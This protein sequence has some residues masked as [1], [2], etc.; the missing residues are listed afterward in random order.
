VPVV[1]L[2]ELGGLA[3][4]LAA[5]VRASGF[6][7]DVLV[8]VE[9]GARLVAHEVG[10]ELGVEV[11]PMWVRRGGSGLKARVAPWVARLPVWVR[12]GLRRLE[13]RSGVHRHTSR[14]AALAEGVVLAGKRVLLLD[15]AADTGRT[16][17]VARELVKTK[18]GAAEVKVAVLAA[19]TPAGRAEV[20]FFVLEKNSRMPWSSDSDERTEAERRAEELR[21]RH[22]PRDF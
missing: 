13:E 12:D 3:G 17:A 14:A 7:A 15:D 21:P 1:T 6:R 16:I 22:A 4:E 20:D 2:G 10:R 9:T 11:V 19:T 18:G 5:R 8:Y